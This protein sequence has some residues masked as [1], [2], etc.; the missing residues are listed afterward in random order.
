M[1]AR[2]YSG[3]DDLLRLQQY[4]AQQIA[5][6]PCGWLHPGDIPHHL[7]NVLRHDD[8]HRLLR[9]WEADGAICGWGL[10]YPD[11]AFVIQTARHDVME[12]VLAWAEAQL[13]SDSI[14]TDLWSGGDPRS[15]LLTRSGYTEVT[16]DLPYQWTTRS[17]VGALPQVS[18]PEG[19]TVRTAAEMPDPAALADVHARSFGSDWTPE[20]YA[21]VM[22]SP[23][24]APEREYV[25][26]APDGRLAAFTVT[27]HDTV[28]RSG[29]F[30]PV[31]TH[32]DF[33]RMG[34]ARAMMAQALRDMQALGLRSAIVVHE[35]PDDNPA[36]A[37]LYTSLGFAVQY[38]LHSYRK[39]RGPQSA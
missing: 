10:V 13:T 28:N 31:G 17:L 1:K 3:A 39:V 14:G 23:G 35:H 26:V 15:A 19:F 30:E 8:P 2:Q 7:Y 12:E 9:L 25:V 18:L 36:S 4:N 5:H 16:G 34:L 38:T 22:Q 33:R 11:D 32:E 27:W 21:R 29:Y 20:L 6:T 24:Y 37:S